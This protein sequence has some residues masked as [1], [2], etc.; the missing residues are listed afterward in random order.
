MPMVFRSYKV[1]MIHKRLVPPCCARLFA[2]KHDR[3]MTALT[4]PR[5]QE[6]V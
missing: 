4:I 5:R 1:G 6:S 3:A 2:D